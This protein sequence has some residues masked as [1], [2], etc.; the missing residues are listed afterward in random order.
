VTPLVLHTVLRGEVVEFVLDRLPN[1]V[2]QRTT[3]HDLLQNLR[4]RLVL[5]GEEL[6][7]EVDIVYIRRPA[8]FLSLSLQLCL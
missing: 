7:E 8:L 6:F 2:I 3:L 4:E 1:Q 5:R